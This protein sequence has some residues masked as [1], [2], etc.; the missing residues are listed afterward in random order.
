MAEVR[1]P[2]PKRKTAVAPPEE[3]APPARKRAPKALDPRAVRAGLK[4]AEAKIKAATEAKP[5]KRRT[6]LDDDALIAASKRARIRAAPRKAAAI[7]PPKEQ[8]SV[9]KFDKADAQKLYIKAL[10]RSLPLFARDILGMEIAP[11]ILDWG[12]LIKNHSRVSINAARG[13]GKSA[14][15]SYAYPIWRAWSEPGVEVY[16]FSATLDQ[17]K[18][19][20]DIIIYGRDNLKGMIDIPALAHL[21]PTPDDIRRDKRLRLNKEDVKFTNLSRIKCV[22]YGKKIRGR[23]PKYIVLDDVLNDEDM[24]SEMVRRKHVDYYK[25]AVSPMVTPTGQIVVVGTPYHQDDLYFGFLRKNAE[26][27]FRSYPG[28]VIDRATGKQKPLFPWLWSLEKLEQKK[29]EIGTVAFTREIMVQP[30]NDEMAIFPSDLFP[31]LFNKT[32]CI[33]PNRSTRRA[34]GIEHSVFMGVD[35]ARSAN[36]GADYFVIFVVGKDDHGNIFILDIIRRKGL[37]FRNQIALIESVSKFYDPQ[38]VFIESNAAQQ[39]LS[40]EVRRTT[41][42]P[43]KEFVTTA[44]NKYPLDKGVPG[45]RILMEN[46]KVFIPRGDDR[47]IGLT[48]AWMFEMQQF[49]F[50]DGKLQGIG[51][52]DDQVMAFWF[53]IEA[54]KHGGFSFGT[55]DEG[56][57]DGSDD[58]TAMGGK[59]WEEIMMGSPDDDVPDDDDEAL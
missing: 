5:R 7:T 41:R 28:L 16:V 56:A 12:D 34:L 47:S 15:F 36:V 8:T 18:E 1:K 42:V 30:I 21:V 44:Q 45:L 51:A 48:N 17:A 10:K 55:G 53:A 14:F 29:R 54:S 3:D 19:F 46:G 6:V 49:G 33:R 38:L 9:V 50:M 13:H 58:D 25:S 59:T 22:G 2:R 57:A 11:H 31:P 20:L 23:H 24:Y 52:H 39:V 4:A 37:Q 35:I 40:D 32:L 27:V 26:Y 43:V